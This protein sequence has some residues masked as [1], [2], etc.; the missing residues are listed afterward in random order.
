MPV[1]KLSHG[2][3]KRTKNVKYPISHHKRLESEVAHGTGAAKR[4][5]SV[6]DKRAAVGRPIAGF[7][8]SQPIVWMM[9][10][11]YVARG[12][13]F[14]I[15][16]AFA[17]LAASGLGAH[18]QGARD[19]LEFLF[20][21]PFGGYFLWLLAIG[22]ACF[23]GWRFMQA[24]FDIERFGN[25]LYGLMRRTVLTGSGVFYVALAAA[26]ARIT[27][28]ERRMDEDQSAR[29]WTAWVMA[30][31][32]GR[33]IIALIGVGFAA[34][35]IGLAAKAVRAP[36]RHRRQGIPTKRIWADTLGSFGT[37][38]RAV[39]FIVIG[40][41]LTIA[42]YDSNSREAVS[43]AGVL[44]AMQEQAHGGMLLSIAALG[45]LAFG[46]FEILEALRPNALAV[47]LERQV[48]LASQPEQE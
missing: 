36:Y 39:V 44:R 40:C 15:V 45:L 33:A 24:V 5:L 7:V 42:A 13:I 29:E 6:A 31:P 48:S 16:G 17:L 32:L 34:V 8:A 20:Q 41:F 28:A 11:G 21:K 30:Q 25:R 14:L 2:Y 47:K 38:T 46:L 23:A 37:L 4:T 9:R 1:L 19:A 35:A 26:S 18:P 10:I 27:F 43:L 12:I 3:A 22:L